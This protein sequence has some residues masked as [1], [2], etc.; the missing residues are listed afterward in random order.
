MPKEFYRS[1]RVA[2]AVQRS[3]AILI[4]QEISDPRLGMVNI[5]AVTVTRDLAHAKVFVTLIGQNDPESCKK[6]VSV[7]NNAANFLRNLVGR[8]LTM[9]SS[10]KLQFIYDESSVRGQDIRQLIDRAIASDTENRND[11]EDP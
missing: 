3:L 7:L 9:R 8:E 6:S 5:N 2:D 1:D 11:T 4:P 10:P